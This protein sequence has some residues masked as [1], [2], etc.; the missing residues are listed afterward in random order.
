MAAYL[1]LVCSITVTFQVITLVIRRSIPVKFAACQL[2]HDVIAGAGWA[3]PLIQIIEPHIPKATLSTR[4]NPAG[5]RR[6]QRT[7]MQWAAGCRG[8]PTCIPR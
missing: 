4:A 1:K 7:Q 3:P 8:K 5:C 2:L 6:G